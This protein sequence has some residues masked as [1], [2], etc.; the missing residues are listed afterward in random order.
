MQKKTLEIKDLDMRIEI[1][2]KEIKNKSSKTGVTP[3]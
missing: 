2:E 1:L 3:R